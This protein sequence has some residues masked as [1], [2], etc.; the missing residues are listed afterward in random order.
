MTS[1]AGAVA[2]RL[3]RGAALAL[4]G[5]VLL[6]GCTGERNYGIGPASNAEPIPLKRSLGGRGTADA[7]PVG[8]GGGAGAGDATG[9]GGGITGSGPG[10]F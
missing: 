10:S 2:G 7:P 9:S 6:A 4:A 3:A 5:A 8:G 1:H